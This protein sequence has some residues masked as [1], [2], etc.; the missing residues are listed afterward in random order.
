MEL[1][2]I[3]LC[4]ATLLIA[5]PGTSAVAPIRNDRV[6]D[7]LVVPD[8]YIVKYKNGI[9]TLGR[10]EH[11]KDVNS[12]ARKGSRRG[13]LG[14]FDVA[15]LRGYVAELSTLDLDTLASF[16]L[17]DYIEKDTVVKAAAV[18]AYPQP[19]RRA[20]VEQ[21]NAPWG[22]AR[23][24]H[25]SRGQTDD[26]SYYYSNTAGS[27]TYVYVI[28][29]GIRVSH[30]DFGGRAV[31]GANFVAASRDTDEA[32]H[33]THVAGIIA[34][35]TYGV[36]KK[37]TVIA[38]KVLDRLGSGSSSGLV[39]G[40]DWA[41]RDARE[42]GTANRSVIN[43]S[44]SG[45]FSQ[46]INDAIQAATD[47][48]LTVVAAA[49]NQG[50]DAWDQSPASAPSAITVGAI[51]RHDNR[52]V[53]SNWGESVDIFAPGVEIE[54]AFNNSD[55]DHSLMNGTSMACPH[56]A[57]LAAYFMARDGISGKEVAQKVLETA[58]T[59]VGDRRMGADRIAYN[60]EAE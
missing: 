23:I 31:W 20:T 50:K 15:G 34:G 36:A 18:A 53:F 3:F 26:D 22:L 7:E 8:T 25:R 16:D 52:A 35:Q 21:V 9:D 42:R 39:Q 12:R 24:S 30:E 49:G 17:I 6:L 11:E 54:S 51:D 4:L 1:I 19:A 57:G 41:V 44:V 32:G 48:G 27:E 47:A 55:S 29:S 58:I 28:D 59:G 46:A 40:L 13:I 60:G 5:F 38:V 14:R 33:G 43:L 10:N 2:T 37:A 56:V 45:P